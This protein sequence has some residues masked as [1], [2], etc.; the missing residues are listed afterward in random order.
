MEK[1]EIKPERR[2]FSRIDAQFAVG[3]SIRDDRFDP[4]WDISL[5]K[6]I[7]CSGILFTTAEDIPS[8]TTLAIRL[9]LPNTSKLIETLMKVAR[10][11][12]VPSGIVY[13]TG[14]YF[15]EID[16]LDSVQIEKAVESSLK[17]S[18]P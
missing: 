12:G 13:R 7:S 5:T 14:A 2:R 9:R 11:E 6:N 16:E 17:K 3:Y 18:T 15:V 4:H 1:S 8:G 10:V